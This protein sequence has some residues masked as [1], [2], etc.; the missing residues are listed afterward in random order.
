MN[1]RVL[2]I[3]KGDELAVSLP[4]W[5]WNS[6]GENAFCYGG[7][8]EEGKLCV[9]LSFEILPTDPD[10]AM[11]NDF[12]LLSVDK[13]DEK[14]FNEVYRRCETDLMERGVTMVSC[15]L[16][17]T[18]DELLTKSNYLEPLGFLS[19]RNMGRRLHYAV[20]ELAETRF[21][22][23]YA[24]MV[25]LDPSLRRFSDLERLAVM[26]FFEEANENGFKLRPEDIDWEWSTFY[27]GE[28]G[29]EGLL[30]VKR[31]GE[32][33]LFID[34]IYIKGAYND[35]EFVEE[36]KT[37]AKTYEAIKQCFRGMLGRVI[38][39][40]DL[41]GGVDWEL[42]VHV[43]EEEVYRWLYEDLGEPI[44]QKRILEFVKVILDESL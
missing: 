17:G 36:E 29:I 1:G 42:Y 16:I 41:V 19:L 44:L 13:V 39:D 31:I 11:I 9:A 12:Y 43:F 4:D 30:S 20:E 26:R 8:D 14:L 5:L 24:A 32:K 28:T 3:N 22:E 10:M 33:R 21:M 6:D 25:A 2:Q 37:D 38:R 18:F 35:G 40:I 23:S 34:G 7:I 15:K 27:V